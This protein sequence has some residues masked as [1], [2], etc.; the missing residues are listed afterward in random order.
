MTI[1]SHVRELNDRLAN[2]ERCAEMAPEGTYEQAKVVSGIIADAANAL[3]H[4]LRAEN[5]KA[6]GDDRLRNIEAAIY[7]YIL[8]SNPNAYELI[9]AEGFGRHVDG[10]SGKRIIADA[11][12]NRDSLRSV[13]GS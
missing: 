2:L 13:F 7:G 9:S 10:P 3:I 4:S 5:L 1:A 12:R 8:D 11:I 6:P